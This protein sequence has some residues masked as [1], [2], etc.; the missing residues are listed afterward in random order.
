ML[1]LARPDRR[2]VLVDSV[3]KKADVL[4][5]FVAS[6]GLANVEVVAERAEMLGRAPAHREPP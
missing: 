4:R 6:L 3:R 1:A 2:W 5:G